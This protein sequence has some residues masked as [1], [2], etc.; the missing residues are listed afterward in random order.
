MFYFFDRVLHRFPSF[1]SCC[2]IDWFTEW[3]EEALLG[4]GLGAL[5]DVESELGIEEQTE[6][7]VDMFKII[8]KSVEKISVRYLNEIRRHNYVT[9]TSYLELLSMYKM[10]LKEKKTK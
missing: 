1:V 5:R 4:V 6:S 2:T 10:I 9:P 8:H 3:P 7:L